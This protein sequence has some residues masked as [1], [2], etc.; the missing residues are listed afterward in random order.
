MLKA[1]CPQCFGF[2]WSTHWHFK[3]LYLNHVW[4]DLLKRKNKYCKYH[5]IEWHG[6][7]HVLLKTCTPSFSFFS[8]SSS[9]LSCLSP[10]PRCR[11]TE[12]CRTS[13]SP[14]ETQKVIKHWLYIYSYNVW[15]KYL[16]MLTSPFPVPMGRVGSSSLTLSAGS[17]TSVSGHTLPGGATGGCSTPTPVTD[18]FGVFFSKLLVNGI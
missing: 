10:H 6:I 16:E 1:T 11:R 7:M 12:S 3:S 9:S 4:K 18:K 2:S 5:M 8:A 15:I 13:T 14:A 17:D